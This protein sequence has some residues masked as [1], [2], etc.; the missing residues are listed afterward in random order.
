MKKL[1]ALLLALLSTVQAVAQVTFSEVTESIRTDTT[2][3]WTFNCTN[4]GTPEGVAILITATD[5]Q[6][7]SDIDSVSFGATSLSRAGSAYSD[8]ATEPGTVEGW[9]AGSSLPTGDQTVTVNFVSANPAPD[10]SFVCVTIQASTDTEVIDTDGLSENQ[11]DPSVT[12]QYSGR[13]AITL[14]VSYWGAGTSGVP[15][16]NANMT[17]LDNHD[18]GSFVYGAARQTTPGTS[19][20]TCSATQAT[21]D[22]AFYCMAISE[23][24]AVPSFTSA[25]SCSATTNGVSCN[26]TASAAST[27]YGVGVAP[28]DGVPT[29]TQI[30]AGQNDGGTAALSSGSDANT[31]TAD[32][33]NITATG[34]IPR[35]DYHFCLNNAG[36]DSA[37]D[38]SQSDKDR[39][40]N[41]GKTL[42]ALTSVASTSFL[43]NPTDATGDTDGSTA[44]ITGM[45]DTSD[46]EVGMLVD[47]SAGFA[48]L[49]D[50]LVF[51][52][53]ATSLTLEINSNSVQANITVTGNDY[54]DP[55][56]ATGDVI[57][58]ATT[59]VCD[60]GTDS[61]VTWDVDGDFSYPATNCGASLTTI[62]YCIQDVSAA[63]GLT[64]T[65]GDCFTTYDKLYLFNSAPTLEGLPDILIWDINV[66]LSG[67]SLSGYCGDADSQPLTYI[68][69]AGAWPTGVSLAVDGTLSGTPT[70]EN[71][72]GVTLDNI[73]QDPGLLASAFDVTVYVIDTWTMPDC[74]GDTVAACITAVDAVAPWYGGV[75][76]SA[77]GECSATVPTDDIISQSP[78]ELTEVDNPLSLINVSV[79][80]GLCAS[81]DLT[82]LPSSWRTVADVLSNKYFVAIKQQECDGDG[83]WAKWRAGT[84]VTPRGSS[85]CVLQRDVIRAEADGAATWARWRPGTN[86]NS[87]NL[88]LKVRSALTVDFVLTPN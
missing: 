62:D 65:P 33:I 64:T 24:A 13:T 42:T 75:G 63:N 74:T 37:V 78:V 76:I 36:G 27:A 16:W 3:P 30:K 60:A 21:D 81:W 34:N 12:L 66:A 68:T 25:P 73:C 38:S 88:Q 14:G 7:S 67:V 84:E 51:N 85:N 53:T 23:V 54:F 43:V 2:D 41:S 48:D 79:S 29:C 15:A 17:E 80:T 71:E 31:G 70:V 58:G 22:V 9:F 18:F 55:D 35:L 6:A 59:A 4:T 50:L 57:E 5:P 87:S 47:V 69:R 72:S 77:D 20:F 44:V 10:Y 39:S 46:F 28:A 19:D 61:P 32:T 86:R 8:T 52:K 49:T 45:T 26:Y 83:V 40:A 56:A 1:T 11:A 82:G